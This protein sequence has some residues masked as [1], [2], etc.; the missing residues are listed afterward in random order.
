M[1]TD[2]EK[3]DHNGCVLI[4]CKVRYVDKKNVKLYVIDT[5]QKIKISKDEF[6]NIAV[7]DN[8]AYKCDNSERQNRPLPNRPPSPPPSGE[9]ASISDNSNSTR[10]VNVGGR[11]THRR[12]KNK[13]RKG[14]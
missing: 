3:I 7:K 13:K 2:L 10:S 8:E 6:D 4:R 11:K 14:I 5:K 12:N 9:Y 1:D